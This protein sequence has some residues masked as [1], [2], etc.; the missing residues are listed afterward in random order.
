[1]VSANTLCRISISTPLLGSLA[2]RKFLIS[3]NSLRK[4][5]K[6]GQKKYCWEKPLNGC[7]GKMLYGKLGI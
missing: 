6:S 3:V 1:M 7:F 2:S 5:L 4:T